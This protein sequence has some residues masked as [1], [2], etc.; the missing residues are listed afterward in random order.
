MPLCAR[1]AVVVAALAALLVG[2]VRA[3]DREFHVAVREVDWDYAPGGGSGVSPEQG[4]AH[5]Y[6]SQGPARIGSVY[7]KAVFRE[8]T[9]Y[10]FSLESPRPA[11]L[12]LLGPVL[13]AEVGDV[14]RVNL[15]N[16]ASRPY[17][18]HPHGVFYDKRSEGAR[19]P[20]GTS[21]DD[22]LDD[23]VP[24]GGRHTYV[25]DVREEF[26]P[27]A[28]DPACL[29]WAYHSHVDASR[30]IAS[31]L[32]GALLTCKR[33]ILDPVTSKRRDVDQEFVVMFAIVNENLS[34]YLGKNIQRFCG[35]PDSVDT[36]D[37]GFV[38]S[39]QMHAINGLVFGHL[40]G[41]E[42]CVGERVAW[43]LLAIGGEKDLHTA[44]FHGQTLSLTGGV[45]VDT[46]GLFAASFASGDAVPTEVG[47]W[48]LTCGVNHHVHAGMQALYTVRDCGRAAPAPAAGGETRRYFVAAEESVWDYGP[49][50]VDAFTGKRLDDPETESATFFERGPTRLGG[51]YKKARFVGYTDASFAQ[52][53]VRHAGEQHLGLMG[54]VLRAQVGDTVVVTFVNRATRPYSIQPHGLL[55][56]K[57][58][59][60]IAYTDGRSEAQRRASHVPPGGNFTY[61]WAVPRSAGP[62]ASDPDCLAWMYFSAVDSIRDTNAG[63]LGPL[64]VC[65]PEALEPSGKQKA[66]DEEFFL[67][68]TVFDENESWYLDD[69]I[70][71]FAGNASAVEKEDAGFQESN[72]MHAINGFMYG[73]QPG[74]SACQGARVSWSFLGVG[75]EVDM[76]GAFVLGNTLLA[77][78]RRIGSLGLF[79]HV[80]RTAS[81][82]ARVAGK[83]EVGCQTADHYLAGMKQFYSV[84]RCSRPG[85][86]HP[87]GARRQRVYYLAAREVDWDYFPDDTWEKE[88]HGDNPEASDA[89][90]FTARGDE[91][92]GSVYKKAMYLEYED[93]TFTKLRARRPDEEH[94]GILGPVLRAEVGDELIV[95]FRNG[96]SRPYSVHAHGVD[97]AGNDTTA[98]DPGKT[99]T[100][101]WEVTEASGPGPS[102]PN[103]V[104]WTYYSRV[105]PVKDLY[106]GLFGPLVVC[107]TGVLGTE[108]R[109]ADVDRE[110]ALLFLIFDENL[111]WY[112]QDNVRAFC[113]HP[114]RVDTS[115]EGFK[116]SNRMHAINGWLYGNARGL[117]MYRGEKVA[118]YLL[119]MGNEVDIHTV[120]FHGETF[121]YKKRHDH[122]GDVHELFPGT[123]DS[124]EMRARNPG[125][126]LL[127]CHLTE[128]IYAGM[129][130]TYHILEG[131]AG[132]AL[133]P[134]TAVG[135]TIL[136][137]LLALAVVADV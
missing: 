32:V 93:A 85:T 94:L 50:G 96:A 81:M 22:K 66:F 40:P 78:G 23:A 110:F 38:E 75:N 125:T 108:G 119:G 64:L 82:V 98:T 76:H 121:L 89:A 9:D 63:L 3:R 43:H 18:L 57:D 114:E 86:A 113:V 55:V 123:S 97:A 4:H 104:T 111:S 6:L 73:N 107:E 105:D 84:F 8:Y 19:Y 106:S 14:L 45:R 131:K 12:G 92:I 88:R 74:L 80:A 11:W 99:H 28:D 49:S 109:R 103:C 70:E 53:T 87:G 79:P 128:H 37:E 51:R 39:N 68:Y 46:V 91:R 52:K 34:W 10:S 5:M 61:T 59:E 130:T 118:W 137:L 7:R 136:A 48:L 83:F 62:A 44:R 1:A 133:R 26:G 120:H 69:N 30:D 35:S 112:L 41:L 33:G 54:P 102:D 42:M 122:R 16:L 65:R 126:W 127:H 67:L 56:T 2:R 13:R 29:T 25:W 58:N 129:E 77:G 100:Y 17:G 117:R 72:K 27:T 20:D 135:M 90:K 15:R 116:E 115:D 31:G 24:P 132:G 60:G 71:R 101:R 95:V 21:G 47:K 36:E 124:V 134:V